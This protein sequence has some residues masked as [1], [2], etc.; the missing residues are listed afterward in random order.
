[1]RTSYIKY[2]P[3]HLT[4]AEGSFFYFPDKLASWGHVNNNYYLSSA[5][6]EADVGSW[7]NE[8]A[9]Y[10]GEYLKVLIPIYIP[11]PQEE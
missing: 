1:M 9:H 5:K 8:I 11:S 3:Q 6:S 4:K 7:E 10:L 2:C